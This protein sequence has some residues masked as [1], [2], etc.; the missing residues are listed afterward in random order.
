MTAAATAVTSANDTH[1]AQWT[2]IRPSGPT[3]PSGTQPCPHRH[4]DEFCRRFLKSPIRPAK[5]SLSST[6]KEESVRDRTDQRCS[7]RCKCAGRR[8][9]RTRD[10]AAIR[11]MRLRGSR[12]AIARSLDLDIKT[13]RNGAKQ[14]QTLVLQPIRLF[15]HASDIHRILIPC[16][17]VI[18]VHCAPRSTVG[19][20]DF[21]RYAYS[22]RK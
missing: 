17:A 11:E 14:G 6:T 10:R 12:K 18:L 19:P 3:V 22:P 15:A 16:S 8:T 1:V 7:T 21:R 13:V 20:Y 4:T 9:D 5:K 2:H